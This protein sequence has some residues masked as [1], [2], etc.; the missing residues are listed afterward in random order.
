MASDYENESGNWNTAQ[1]WSS[2]MIFKP[3]YEASQ[4]LTISKFG[5]SSIEEDFMFDEP[6]KIRS[7]I[8][9]IEWARHKI[10]LGIRQCLFAI[11]NPNDKNKIK[12]FLKEII[13]LKIVMKIIE[14]KIQDRDQVI[15]DINEDAFNIAYDVLTR[16]F[17]EVTEPMNKS[18][19]IFTFKERFDSKEFKEE[20]KKRFV[21]G[22]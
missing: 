20:V 14:T 18:D 19:L 8:R 5:C 4:Y 10:E 12:D 3:F 1:N 16:I 15:I 21:E 6:I 9:A 13:D 22:D 7:R 11:K 2:E 17:T